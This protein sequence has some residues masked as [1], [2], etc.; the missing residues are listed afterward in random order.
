MKKRNRLTVCLAA[1]VMILAVSATAAFGSVNGYSTYKEAV[2]KLALKTDNVTMNGTMSFAMDGKERMTYQMDGSLAGTNH[3]FHTVATAGGVTAMDTYS[4]TLNGVS[5]SFQA[6]AS[7][8]HTYKTETDS[9]TTN[10]MGI[11]A[12]D[13]M[14]NRLINF[15]E[16]AADTVVGDLK[17]NFVQVG[18]K[19]GSTLYQV[20]ISKSQVPSLVNAGLSLMAYSVAEQDNYGTIRW[21]DWDKTHLNNYEKTT[22]KPM[23]AEM[24]E[25]YM[26]DFKG[27]EAFYEK[28][29]DEM[30]Q[31]E[32]ASETLY[33]TYQAQL[34]KKGDVGILFVKADGS[35]EYYAAG[36]DFATAH[37]EAAGEDLSYFIGED[38]SLET[39]SCT[40]GVD[41]NG[42]LTSNQISATFSTTEKD[43]ARHEMTVKGDVTLK[44][45]GTTVISPLDVG[46]R[47]EQK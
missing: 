8:Y 7:Y 45:Y 12:D 39:V 43:G 17:N 42:N 27:D 16:I 11:E 47:T 41:K 20:N 22:G 44:D 28:H 6:D 33:E 14:S 29:E 19:D 9:A 3:A 18:E 46:N 37:P 25:Y 2:K 31:I 15:M 10:L 4:T 34:E 13:E 40:F 38:M 21:E 1:G 30:E 23:S 32:K 24:K 5:T 26:G 35:T 36:K